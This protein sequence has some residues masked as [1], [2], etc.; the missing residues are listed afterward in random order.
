MYPLIVLGGHAGLGRGEILGLQKADLD[1]K[2][3][4]MIVRRHVYKDNRGCARYL[5]KVTVTRVTSGPDCS[6][7]ARNGV[8]CRLSA[9]RMMIHGEIDEYFYVYGPDGYVEDGVGHRGK[10]PP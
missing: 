1:F 10:R 5:G 4:Q 8:P 7:P 3:R 2:R 6:E 9:S